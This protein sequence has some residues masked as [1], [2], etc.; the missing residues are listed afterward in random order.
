MVGRLPLFRERR[1]A[2][3]EEQDGARALRILGGLEQLGSGWF[4]ET[5]PEGCLTYISER[6]LEQAGLAEEALVGRPLC[7]L[8]EAIDFD[9]AGE[10]TLDFHLRSRAS[11]RELEVRLVGVPQSC[12]S[13]SGRGVVERGLFRGFVGIGT[14]LNGRRRAE[15]EVQ[16]LAHSDPLTGLANRVKMRQHLEQM[17][18]GHGGPSRTPALLM[19]DLDRFKQV[20]DTLGHQTGDLLL[21]QVAERL[22]KAIGQAGIPGRIGGDEFQIVIPGGMDRHALKQRAREVIASL[23]RPYLVRGSSVSVGCS[24]GIAVAP[25]DGE[26]AD[27]LVRN[28]DLA[29]YA[30]KNAGRGTFSFFN[31]A[32]LVQ[33]QQRRQLEDDLREALASEQL[34]V[35]YQPIVSTATAQVT[36][37][38][39]LLR[40]THPRRG[41]ISPAVFIPVAEE[42]GLIEQ[43]GAWVLR[44][45]T[46]EAAAWPRG[47]RVAVNVSPAQFAKPGFASL[48]AQAIAGSRLE[49]DR[50]E[51]E[52]TESVF[53][54]EDDASGPIF[55]SLKALGVRLAL[56]DFGTG[57]SS[58][59]RL[60]DVPFDKLK[61][62]Q[63]FVRG[64]KIAGN[65]DIAII[66]AIVTLAQ[67][68][69][70]ETV[71][72]GVEAQ[73][74]ITMIRDLGCTHI[75]GYVYGRPVPATEARKML[76]AE[77]IAPVGVRV[78]RPERVRMLRSITIMVDGRSFGARLRNLSTGGALIDNVEGPMLSLGAQISLELTEGEFVSAVVRRTDGTNAG[79]EWLEPVQHRAVLSGGRFK[80][81]A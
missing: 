77:Q 65:R 62:D 69:G 1:A 67:T 51:L 47:V 22:K 78:T 39:A 13:L 40:W 26:D 58:L 54:G 37:F 28:A 81:P 36:G 72:E 27:T 33:A 57:Y 14:D 18:A 46:A 66:K 25:D 3:P 49:A 29:L 43:I 21:A 31:E 60:K 15:A 61:I 34:S 55:R 74:E 38:E 73:D 8:F 56:D 4:W 45:A 35:V 32:L 11:F 2:V 12:W 53:V 24:I 76:G 52:I 10:R 5:S 30:A 75:Q 17:C 80:M 42:A 68:L 64:A 23:S 48:V 71:A 6:L 41:P 7:E 16:R 63:S 20:N 70:L 19:L 50:L 79:V 59:G 44:A 9:G